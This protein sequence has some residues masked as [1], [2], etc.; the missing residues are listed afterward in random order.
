M[1]PQNKFDYPDL[2]EL[3]PG[4]TFDQYAEKDKKSRYMGE[5]PSEGGY[6]WVY[7]MD[8]GDFDQDYKSITPAWERNNHGI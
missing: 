7:G 6:V 5:Y 2:S 3:F 4:Y 1:H 8:N